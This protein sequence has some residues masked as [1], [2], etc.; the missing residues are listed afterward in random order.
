[1]SAK[2]CKG[3]RKGMKKK[4]IGDGVRVVGRAGGGV[5]PP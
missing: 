1:M 3:M 4:G 2:K 5:H